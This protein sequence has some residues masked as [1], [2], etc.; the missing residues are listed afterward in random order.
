MSYVPLQWKTAVI[1][2]I[3]KI[4]NPTSPSDFRPISVDP[5]LSRILEK[6]IV[7][8]QLK[9]LGFFQNLVDSGIAVAL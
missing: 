4:P 3:P 8:T 9:R 2:S 1:S 5:I 6:I 7:K